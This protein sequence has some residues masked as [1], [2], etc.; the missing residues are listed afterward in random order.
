MDK[1]E[2]MS[3]KN[4]KGEILTAYRKLLGKRDEEAHQLNFNR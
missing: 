1:Q 2:Q 3:E 4:T